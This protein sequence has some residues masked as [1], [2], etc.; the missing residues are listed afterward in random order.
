MT[1]KEFDVPE[2]LRQQGISSVKILDDR[3]LGR[4]IKVQYNNIPITATFDPNNITKIKR[5]FRNDAMEIIVPESRTKE[6]ADTAKKLIES[7][8]MTVTNCVQEYIEANMVAATTA[9]GSQQQL[10]DIFVMKYT[11]NPELLGDY[12]NSSDS[13][14]HGDNNKKEGDHDEEEDDDSNSAL[15]TMSTLWETVR[16]GGSHFF[17]SYDV[18]QKRVRLAV[19]IKEKTGRV[20]LPYNDSSGIEP[21]SFAS[22][23]E[24]EQYIQR[25]R[26]ENLGTLFRKVQVYVKLFY[27]TDIQAYVD[28]VAA[29]TI[30]TYFQDRLGKTHYLFIYGE[31]GTGKGV[32]LETINQLAYRAADVTSITGPVL[33]RVMGS[34]ERGQ[35][36]MIIDEANKLEDDAL[37]LN[38]LK[39]GYKGNQRVPRIVDNEKNIIEWFY[40][41]C[42]KVIAAERLPSHWKTGGLLSRCLEIHSAPGRPAMD[43]G[44]VLERAND[45]QNIKVLEQ[46]EDLRKLLFAYRLLHHHEPIADVRIK[47]IYGRDTELVKPLVRLFRTLGDTDSLETIKSALH[48]FLKEGN[49]KKVDSLASEVLKKIKEYITA[50]NE[51]KYE[52][53]T[54][55]FWEFLE[56]EMNGRRV[57]DRPDTMKF[58]LL[59]EVS[60]TKLGS[61]LRSLGGQSVKD[62]T[63]SKRVWRFDGKT[64]ERLSKIYYNEMPDKIEIIEQATLPLGEKGNSNECKFQSSDASDTFDVF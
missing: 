6:A 36:T 9:N 3:R 62:R 18:V 61:V 39:V 13:N 43:I 27:D 54:A 59:G 48:H 24:L 26:L 60:K 25:A 1:I 57:D 23:L 42:F 45:P 28:I 16:I 5:D 52:F 31:P 21:Y 37:L 33:Y 49:R 10:R 53:A 4:L 41:Y 55:E 58:D 22:R 14:H 15:T 8:V 12:N 11:T 17:T 7:L 35:V 2:K 47:D 20:I 50:K 64:L 32:I 56:Y 51:G 19:N 46:L 40:A 44:D 29:D 38:V 63:G 34:V 30:F